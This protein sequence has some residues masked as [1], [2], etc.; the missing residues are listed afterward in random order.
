M[1]LQTLIMDIYDIAMITYANKYIGEMR[2]H[3]QINNK[4]ESYT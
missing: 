1:Y 2:Y 3:E 4:Y